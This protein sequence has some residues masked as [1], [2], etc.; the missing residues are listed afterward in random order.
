MLLTLAGVLALSSCAAPDPVS[1]TPTP[2]P[3]SAPPVQAESRPDFILPCYPA[4]GFH[5]ITG[6]NRLNLTLAPLIYRGLFSVD[7][8][9][10]A[11]N[12][13][14]E[15]YEVSGDGLTWTFRLTNAVFSDGTPLTAGE[16]VSSL[17]AAR[18]SERYGGRLS[19][20]ERIGTEGETVVVTLTRPNGSLPL[21]LDIPIVKEGEDPQRPLGTGPYA[22]VEGEEGLT[23][24]ARQGAQTPLE[25]IPLRTVETGDDL[26]YAFDAQ[27]ISLVDTDLTG[28][29]ALGYSGRLET[30]DYPT[31]TLLYVGCNLSAGPC[32]SQLVRQAVGLALD[33]ERVVGRTLAGH[34]VATTLPAHP[35]APGYDGTLAAQ[36]GQDGERARTLLEEDG[37]SLNEE[38]VLS[39]R[40]ETL[41]LRLIV[42]Q[43]NTFKT[44]A[45]EEIAAA[46][47]ELGCQVTV[48]K[49]SWED[50]TAALGKGEFDLYLGET[51]LTADFNLEA[52]LGARGELNHSGFADEE[53]W[54]LMDQCRTARGDE[55]QSTLVNLCGR[56][57]ELAPIIPVCFK[58]GS[59][60]TQW[61]QVT[62]AAPTQRDVFAGFANWSIGHS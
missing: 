44:A 53:A 31:T 6:S 35:A 43:D 32:R 28:V 4:G 54:E 55:R 29:N 21:L 61:G 17:Q 52:L 7:R 14:C 15:S 49:L 33:R 24:V 30:T 38:G 22:L 39:R 8:N 25:T 34:A 37:W 42:N 2:Q 12:D 56:I 5:P 23:L 13:L 19:D 26:I 11:Q 50:F 57:A 40:R 47:E 58:N 59:L 10:Q 48:D 27:E 46:L 36:W 9:F 20:V 1:A 62:G 51:A 16:V 45:A 3:T 41:A 60:L 18:R